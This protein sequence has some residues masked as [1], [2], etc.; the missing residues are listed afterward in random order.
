MV[1]IF[2]ELNSLCRQ[3]NSFYLKII[4]VY[5]KYINIK[6]VKIPKMKYKI[7]NTIKLIF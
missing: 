3:F 5:K 7:V 1:Y 4:K 6:K 2:C